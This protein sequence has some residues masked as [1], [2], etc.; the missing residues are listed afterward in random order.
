M[1]IWL[2]IIIFVNLNIG[3]CV[4]FLMSDVS[5]LRKDIEELRK[6]LNDPY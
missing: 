3:I 6:R 2:I 5:M 1:N 4:L